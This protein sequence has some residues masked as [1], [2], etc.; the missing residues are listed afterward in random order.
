N[1]MMQVSFALLG[2]MRGGP[3][4]VAVAS[5]ALNGVV[6]GSSVANVVSGGIF[7][8]P[9]MKRAGYGGVKAGAIET[10]ASVNG[11]IM[12]PVMGAA[13]FLMTEYVG[14][15]YAEVVKHAILPACLAYI[16]LFYIVHLEALKLDLKPMLAQQPK[17]VIDKLKGYGLG[18]F[19]SIVVVCLVYYAVLGARAMLGE[20]AAWLVTL[21]MGALYLVATW[22]A[23]RAPDL[24]QDI[25][26]RNPVR[27]ETWPTVRAGLHFLIPIGVL[28]WMLMVDET[29]PSLA[30]FWGCAT[31]LFLMIT[32]HVLIGLFRGRA[33]EAVAGLVLGVRDAVFG[34]EN[35][36]RNMVGMA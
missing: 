29:S 10:M 23:A 26:I 6:S 28:I 34:L 12:P 25:D 17:P 3:A 2:H 31:L 36:A 9:L 15:P 16:G 33:G 24:P 35:G 5:S 14:I 11:Q 8:I 19:G 7:T 32:Q 4:K 1:Y 22:Q 20:S 13:A 18:L 30:A 27:P 21:I